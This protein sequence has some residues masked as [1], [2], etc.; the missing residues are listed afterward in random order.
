MYIP[1]PM[2]KKKKRI[3]M[4]IYKCIGISPLLPELRLA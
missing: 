4:I 2:K 1:V 3:M